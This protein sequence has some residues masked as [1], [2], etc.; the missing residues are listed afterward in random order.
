MVNI[1]I[2]LI[3]FSATKDGEALCSQEKQDQ[4]LTVAQIMKTLLQNSDL[5]Y[6]KWVSLVAQ[7]VKN[8][9]AMQAQFSSWVRKI[10]WRRDRLPTPVFLG[11]PGG[12]DGKEF[13]CSTGNLGSVPGSGRS[14]EGGMATHSS[15]LGWRIHMDRG[16]CQTTVHG[17]TNSWTQLS[18]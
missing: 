15:I 16:A 12:S 3:I 1:E 5:K 6:R 9:R 14:L 10:P 4:E 17:V 18:G 13:T 7:L 2:R 11:F 8:P